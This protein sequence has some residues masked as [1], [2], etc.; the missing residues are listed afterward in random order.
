MPDKFK[1]RSDEKELLDKSN[2][3][4]GLLYKNLRE[5]DILNRTTGGYAISLKGIKQLI[6]DHHKIYHVVDLG[7]GS[8]GALKTIADWARLNN[9]SVRLTGVDM[10]ANAIDYLKIHCV[11]YS[12]IIGIT[13]DYQDYLNRNEVIDIVHCSLFCH[14]LKD[15]ELL[16]LFI[17]FHQHVTAGFIINDLHRNWLAYYSAWLFTRLLNGSMLAKNDGPVSVL[18]GF[19]SGE[20]LYLL[21]KANIRNYSIKKKWL[22]RFLIVGKTQKYETVER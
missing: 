7:C 13:I 8:G 11:N 12:E 3:L 1:Y 9:Y 15:D 22:F 14:H 18:R 6:T 21:N 10:N 19:K 16:R 20:L 2:I 5:L 17:Y 4:R